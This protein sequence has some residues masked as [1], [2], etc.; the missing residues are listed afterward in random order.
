MGS[1]EETKGLALGAKGCKKE[2]EEEGRIDTLFVG[3]KVF[4]SFF[5]CNHLICK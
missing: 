1:L 3:Q 5:L 4:F 2:E